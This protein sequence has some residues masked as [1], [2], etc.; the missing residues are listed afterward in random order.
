M[1]W[2][3]LEVASGGQHRLDGPHAVVI[4]VLGG[5]LLRAQAIRGHD[6]HREGAG[7][8]KATG[9]QHNLCNES[10]IRHHHGHRTEQSLWGK[11]EKRTKKDTVEK[12]KWLL[13]AIGL[14]KDV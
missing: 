11:T 14:W 10:I 5:E 8:D 6:F 12:L 9:V 2:V 1:R 7:S 13:Y 4:V 3:H